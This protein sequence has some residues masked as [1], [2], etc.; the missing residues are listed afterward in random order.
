MRKIVWAL[1][2]LGL[3]LAMGCK[4]QKQGSNKELE[5]TKLTKS[6]TLEEKDSKGRVYARREVKFDLSYP[7]NDEQLLEL[8]DE[9]VFPEEASTDSTQLAITTQGNPLEESVEH[10]IRQQQL[11]LREVMPDST[12]EE[13]PLANI[14]DLAYHLKLSL[15]NQDEQLLSMQSSL[16]VYE[17]GAHGYE[18]I[19]FFTI[20]RKSYQV[21]QESDL[22]VSGYEAKMNELLQKA[23]EEE[24]DSLREDEPWTNLLLVEP[25]EIMPN[26]NFYISP[27]GITYCFN[28]YEIT[29][30]AVGQVVVTIP[31]ESLLPILKADAPIRYLFTP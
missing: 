13:E 26:G 15:L 2:S 3:L 20:D 19:H 28:P 29:P 1:C 31:F 12:Y 14:L 6:M 17:G 5:W 27:E 25:S 16:Y 11:E 7:K 9:I 23:I 30:Y 18:G 10:S 22:F 24:L 4:E 8:I 21:L